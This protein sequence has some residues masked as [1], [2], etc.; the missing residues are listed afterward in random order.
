VYDAFGYHIAGS[1]PNGRVAGIINIWSCR[2]WLAMFFCFIDPFSV[3]HV[4]ARILRLI[5]TGAHYERL[6]SNDFG[7]VKYFSF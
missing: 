7:N 5:E 3:A 4:R 1:K 2:R 6:L